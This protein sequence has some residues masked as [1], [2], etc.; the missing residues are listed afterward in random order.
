MLVGGEDAVEWMM[1]VNGEGCSEGLTEGFSKKIF[2]SLDS[3]C[4]LETSRCTCAVRDFNN[5]D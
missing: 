1:L 2:I 3:I 4:C 5:Y